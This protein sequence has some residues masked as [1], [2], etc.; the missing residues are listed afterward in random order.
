MSGSASIAALPARAASACRPS[1][2]RA[3]ALPACA[4]ELAGCRRAA[5][6]Y[7]ERAAPAGSSWPALPPPA[8]CHGGAPCRART[9][10]QSTSPSRAPPLPS[11][12]CS[13]E[14]PSASPA[15]AAS[16]ADAAPGAP[17]GTLFPSTSQF[18][19]SPLLTAALRRA[20]AGCEEV[21][22]GAAGAAARTSPRPSTL[23]GSWPARSCAKRPASWGACTSAL[24]CR[25]WRPACPVWAAMASL[26]RSDSFFFVAFLPLPLRPDRSGG[27]K[28]MRVNPRTG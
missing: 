9:E 20:A 7:A 1:A 4:A 2:T 8:G 17:A 18:G 10:P 24:F 21:R 25:L 22:A 26:R 19:H 28:P 12:L 3:A 23:P 16:G 11:S 27:I 14:S 15:A 6:S 13:S 5:S